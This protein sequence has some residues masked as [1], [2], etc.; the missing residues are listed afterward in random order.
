MKFMKWFTASAGIVCLL[1][2]VSLGQSED[3]LSDFATEDVVQTDNV[4]VE[5]AAVETQTV[6]STSNADIL[7]VRLQN[8][9]KLSGRLQVL[10]PT[11]KSEPADAKVAFSQDGGLVDT[12]R[13]DESGHFHVQGLEPGQYIATASVGDASTDFQVQVLEFDPNA[14]PD[15]MFLEGTLTPL[16]Q[17][18]LI[19]DGGFDGGFGGDCGGC[20]GC[21]GGEVI[22][23]PY[24][25]GEEIIGDYVGGDIIGEPIYDEGYVVDG[26]IVD[27]G[28]S[29]CGVESF[30]PPVDAC[31]C[32]GGGGYYEPVYGFTGGG[33]GGRGFGIG[34]LLGVGGLA[35]GV[36][37]LA[38][39]DDDV[40]SP[41]AP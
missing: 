4:V 8:D 26:G 28:C 21:G 36:T 35:A 40:V 2:A 30:A 13:T 34:G 18:E 32:S 9:G 12:I 39:D 25:G 6:A 38:I 41:A 10:Y 5:E 37:A 7:N 27:G 15:E 22:S 19:L 17:D 29:T 23:E 11:G 3:L 14:D 20:C 1:A 24:Y 33:G 16:P 31:G